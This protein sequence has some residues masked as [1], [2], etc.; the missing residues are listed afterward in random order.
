MLE[1]L[2]GRLTAYLKEGGMTQPD[3]NLL[4][5]RTLLLQAFAGGVVASLHASEQRSTTSSRPSTERGQRV[6]RN[7]IAQL[8]EK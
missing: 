7:R 6:C 4:T 1:A 8:R 3:K 5:R 2:G